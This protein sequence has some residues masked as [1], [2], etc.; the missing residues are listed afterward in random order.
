MTA[1]KIILVGAGDMGGHHARAWTEIGQTIAAIVD[2]DSPRSHALAERYRV[3]QVFEQYED[4]I[5]TVGDADIVDICL[6]LAWHLPVTE[7]AAQAHKHILCEKPLARDL[8]EADAMKR[9]VEAGGVKFA[10]GF[11]RNLAPGVAMLQEEVRA[12][13]FGRPLLFTADGLGEVRPKRFM[14]DRHGNNGPVV[15]LLQHYFL[16]WES[17]FE[18]QPISI[19]A[20]GY[21]AASDRPEIQQFPEK[22]IDTAVVTVRYASGDIGTMTVSWGLAAGTRVP[23]QPE[24]LIGPRRVAVA[25]P[26]RDFSWEGW[27]FFDGPDES[28][29]TLPPAYPHAL[30]AQAF[31]D[32][33]DGKRTAPPSSLEDG[34]RLLRMS[35]VALKAIETGQVQVL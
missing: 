11:Q 8:D 16:L 2:I 28:Y 31:I 20:S 12:G 13:H 1:H 22:A 29:R 3:G 21:I 27:T 32:Y 35:L 34:R 10:V 25:G 26:F 19:E 5:R 24:R 7:Q 17:V 14:H 33:V 4:A 30:Q 6:P 15:D 9:A 23:S 18:S